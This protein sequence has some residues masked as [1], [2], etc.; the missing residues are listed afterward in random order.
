MHGEILKAK[1][2]GSYQS[3]SVQRQIAYMNSGIYALINFIIFEDANG[4]F[5]FKTDME[6]ICAPVLTEVP[7][8]VVVD[9]SIRRR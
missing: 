1:V 2:F 8:H 4:M 9:T 5:V 6:V 7:A 3:K